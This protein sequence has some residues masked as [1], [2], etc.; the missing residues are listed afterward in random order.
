MMK[1]YFIPYGYVG[2]VRG[3][4]MIFATE[5]EYIEYFKESNHYGKNRDYEKSKYVNQ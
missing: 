5:K 4:W 3:Q 2:F 1:G